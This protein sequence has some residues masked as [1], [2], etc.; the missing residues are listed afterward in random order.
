V[1][2]TIILCY[3]VYPHQHIQPVGSQLALPCFRYHE[4]V[5]FLFPTTGWEWGYRDCESFIYQCFKV[6]ALQQVLRQ[7]LIQNNGHLG[8]SLKHTFYCHWVIIL[9]WE[10]LISY[11]KLY[12]RFSTKLSSS[13]INN[14]N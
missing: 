8:T 4:D 11:N 5:C 6:L 7:N 12:G 1:P 2:Q 13:F 9:C 3:D 10:F 14:K